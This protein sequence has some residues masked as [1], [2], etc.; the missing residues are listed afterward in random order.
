MHIVMVND[1]RHSAWDTREEAEKQVRVLKENGYKNIRI[2]IDEEI[3]V[4]NG[5]YFI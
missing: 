2:I 1:I 4:E 5:Y 3:L